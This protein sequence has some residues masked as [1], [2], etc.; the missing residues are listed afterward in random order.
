[1]STNNGWSQVYISGLAQSVLP[2]NDELETMLEERYDLATDTDLHWA[3]LGS[4]IVKRADDGACRGYAFLSFLSLEGATRAIEK[5]NAAGL[6]KA[7]LSNLKKKPK[8]K[9]TKGSGDLPNIRLRRQRKA[10]AAKHP[11]IVSSNGRRTG[12]GNKTK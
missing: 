8:K 9:E 6:L 10:P 4:S 2:N 11:V 5:I 7:E 3:G 12:L 1:M